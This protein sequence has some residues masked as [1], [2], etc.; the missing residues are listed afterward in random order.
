VDLIVLTELFSLGVTAEALRT[1]LVPT[2][3]FLLVNNPLTFYY[4]L[5]LLLLLKIYT[6]LRHRNIQSVCKSKCM[7]GIDRYT[8]TY[9]Y[10]KP[11][12]QYTIEGLR[13]I[14]G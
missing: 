1:I 7:R 5:L 10:T 11:N 6:A 8:Y 4:L 13:A 3:D 2:N 14:T 12:L 9:I